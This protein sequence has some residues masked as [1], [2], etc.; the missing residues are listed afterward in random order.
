MIDKSQDLIEFISKVHN[1]QVFNGIRS[2]DDLLQIKTLSW[3]KKFHLQCYNKEI[4]HKVMSK[5]WKI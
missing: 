3:S 4:I 5:E 2:E 1:M